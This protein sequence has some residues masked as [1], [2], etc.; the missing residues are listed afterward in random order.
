MRSRSTGKEPKT[1]NGERANE[2]LKDTIGSAEGFFCRGRVAAT[3][4]SILKTR[5]SCFHTKLALL[6]ADAKFSWLN[7]RDF[8]VERSTGGRISAVWLKD[9]DRFEFLCLQSSHI[10]R[11]PPPPGQT[12]NFN[13]PE[14][15]GP[16]IIVLSSVFITFMWPILILRLFSKARVLRSFGWDDGKP[17][18]SS[19][20]VLAYRL[21]QLSLS[22]QQSMSSVPS[23]W[24]QSCW[25]TADWHHSIR[26]EHDMVDDKS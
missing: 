12:S 22:S 15:M 9:Y 13:D 8:Q 26:R 23:P 24:W 6:S 5:W 1:V 4:W 21:T 17:I 3:W 7:I 10:P 19:D 20:A 11:T 14:T 2:I 25:I 16:H 18:F